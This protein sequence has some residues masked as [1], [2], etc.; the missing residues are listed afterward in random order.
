MLL[1]EGYVHAQLLV[2]CCT[3]AAVHSSKY[4]QGIECDPDGVG[5]EGASLRN[6]PR[7]DGCGCGAE[8][9]LPQPQLPEMGGGGAR[10]G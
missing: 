8:D 2:E 3:P 10:G 1:L 5:D 7:H 6:R 4:S 9:P